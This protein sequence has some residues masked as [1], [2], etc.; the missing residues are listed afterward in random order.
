[1]NEHEIY[2]TGIVSRIE[3]ALGGITA[4]DAVEALAY[5]SAAVCAS[6]E[7]AAQ[8]DALF[9]QTYDTHFAKIWALMQK[10]R[11]EDKAPD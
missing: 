9:K 8:T 5:A 4:G 2:I 3:T 10:S 11:Y 1:M 6:S 7:Q